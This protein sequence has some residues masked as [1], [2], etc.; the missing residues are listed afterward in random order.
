MA[1]VKP[2]GDPK[3]P[4]TRETILD[5]AMT[6][7]DG[8]RPEFSLR[9]LGEALGVHNTA[10]YRHFRDKNQLLLA[11]ADRALVDVTI[12]S[13]NAAD[14]IEGVADVCRAVRRALL[15][16]PAAASV[17]SQGPTRQANELALTDCVLGLLLK[18][19]LDEQLAVDAYHGLVEFTVGSSV[20][21]QPIASL[22]PTQRED[23]YRRWRADYLGLD[24][25]NFPHLVA[26][27]PLMYHDSGDQFEF[28][29][30]LMLDRLRDLATDPDQL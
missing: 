12:G 26:L 7:L 5:A 9:E 22:P 27:A 18:A 1:T 4:L 30:R 8:G 10:F 17:L 19:G 11:A 24:K 16:R 25:N 29:L 28:G 6:L 2:K 21:D 14:P 13:Q 3:P 23:T 20:I 15:T